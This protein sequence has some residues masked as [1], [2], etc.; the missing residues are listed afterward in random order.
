MYKYYQTRENGSWSVLTD[1]AKSSAD[2]STVRS[3][4]Q[5]GAKKLTILS[6]SEAVDDY[7]DTSS[8][9]YKGP[10]YFDIDCKED[11][12]LAIRS[13]RELVAALLEQDVRKECIIVYCS[14]SKGLHVLVDERAFSSGRAV[15]LL[16]KVY[17]EMAK[18]LYVY[19]MDYGV[20]CAQRGNSFRIPNQQREDGHFRVCITH[21]ELATLTPESYKGMVGK[22]RPEIKFPDK[23]EKGHSPYLATLFERGKQLVSKA[24]KRK[25]KTITTFS[26]AALQSLKV[27]IPPCIRLMCEGEVNKSSN[28]NEIAL[29][30]AK[31]LATSEADSSTINQ[32][33]GQLAEVTDSSTYNN[34]RSRLQHISGLVGYCSHS[35]TYAFTCGG[36]KSVLAGT[37]C[38]GCLLE[39]EK[40]E[41]DKAMEEGGLG[42]IEREDGYYVAG[43]DAERKIT[44]FTIEL[45]DYHTEQQQ[46]GSVERRTGA[47]ALLKSKGI[48]CEG[49]A[50]IFIAESMWRSKSNFVI[51]IEGIANLSFMGSDMDVQRIKH[52]VF[53]KQA[54]EAGKITAVFT[55]GVLRQKVGINDLMVYVEPDGSINQLGVRDTHYLNADIVCPPAL[56]NEP[57]AQRKDE[58]VQEAL[59]SLMSVNEAFKVGMILGWH[60]AA[61][62][63]TQFVVGYNQ[64]PLLSLW[65]PAGAGKSKTAELFCFLNGCDYT[66]E[67]S[68][69]NAAKVSEW[70]LIDY[71]SSTTTSPRILDEANESKMRGRYFQFA[72]VLKSAWGNISIARGTIRKSGGTSKGRTGARTVNIPISAPLIALSEQS[73]TMPALQH[74]CIQVFLTK[75]GRESPECYAAFEK[76]MASKPQLK[77]LGKALMIKALTTKTD[78]VKVKISQALESIPTAYDDRPRYSFAVL[79]VGLGLLGEVCAELEFGVGDRIEELKQA[80]L[81]HVHSSIT[82]ILL[83]KARSDIDS[84]I[85]DMGLMASVTQ[86]GLSKELIEGVHYMVHQGDLILDYRSAFPLYTHYCAKNRR[87]VIIKDIRQFRA[88]IRQEPYFREEGRVIGFGNRAAMILDGKAMTAK[89]I[90]LTMFGHVGVDD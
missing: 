60:A 80:V 44:N 21:E 32:L 59:L 85:S 40:S 42:L 16:P 3:A 27:T 7:T 1:A 4:L 63:K 13:A 86:A 75:D 66:A 70:A 79:L 55:A 77:A 72:E 38:G 36:V 89:G 23:V 37:P 18:D 11:L 30:M 84:V 6:V 45:Q 33:C 47:K 67:W 64:F 20:Y 43:I 69:I 51:E 29:Q 65:G 88:L 8:L 25:T 68:P 34:S 83:D 57:V 78:T 61:H 56:L 49:V 82:E 74:R 17:K 90:D 41:A 73:M 14:G 50:E 22:P 15:K 53:T 31:Y 9:S 2:D 28:F 10:L 12:Y 39:G 5:K 48:N 19:G 35:K 62:F 76:A 26:E 87:D 58:K 81:L 71:C 24:E 54:D 52:Y 46:D